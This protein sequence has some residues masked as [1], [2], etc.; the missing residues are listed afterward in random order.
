MTLRPVRT[1]LTGEL[2]GL[3]RD[4]LYM[5]VTLGAIS[6]ADLVQMALVTHSLGLSEF[7]RLALVM[8][9]V[10]LV[11]Q[12]FDVRVG[13]AET[14]YGARR[15]AAGDWAGAAGVLRFGYGIDAVT[16]VAGFL[17]VAL[18]APFVGPWL[19]GSDGTELMILYA[20]TLLA[21][22]V[23]ESSITGLRLTGR[24]RLLATYTTGLE[25]LRVVFVALALYVEPS[26]TAVLVALV[27]Y[28]LAG[29]AANL[30]IA[31]GVFSRLAGRPLLARTRLRFTERRAMLG[32]VFHTN[33]VSY[34]RIAQLAAD[35]R[36]GGVDD[37]YAGRSLQGGCVRRFD[38]RPNSGSRLHIDAAAALSAV[39]RRE[40]R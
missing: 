17:I 35:A 40:A 30:A 37:L 10:V 14:T 5:T 28:D 2:G 25:V 3:T 1:L 31:N 9:F 38:R 4:S 26:L 22:T 11:G 21:S 15:I 29:A 23:D 27:L 24:F 33:L 19:V 32:T 8:S 18:A 36:L 12:F 13:T 16:G 20:L 7:G 39:G 6:A 34:A